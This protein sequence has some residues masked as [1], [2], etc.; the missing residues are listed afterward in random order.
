MHHLPQKILQ[1]VPPLGKDAAIESGHALQLP[2]A[3]ALSLRM[4]TLPCITPAQIRANCLTTLSLKVQ[5]RQLF[6]D[7]H[8]GLQDQSMILPCLSRSSSV[9]NRLGSVFW[10][11]VPPIDF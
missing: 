5:R 7:L 8:P 11:L 1:T 9:C 6:I 4:Q 2:L 10:R 3:L